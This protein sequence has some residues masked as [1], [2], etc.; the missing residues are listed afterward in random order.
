MGISKL[1]IVSIYFFAASFSAASAQDNHILNRL[2]K[3]EVVSS[4]AGASF[5]VQTLV[6]QAPEKVQ[7]MLSDL[8]S[9]PKV[10]PQIAFAVPYVGKGKDE[11]RNFLYLKMRGLGDGM[12]LLME[13]KSGGGEAFANAK[14]LIVNSDYSQSRATESEVDASKEPNHLEL[15][16][17]IDE[18]NAKGEDARFVGVGRSLILEGPLNYVMEMPNTR[19]TI[20]IGVSPYTQI[21]VEKP[22]DEK[23]A[24]DPKAAKKI[25]A[26]EK[27]TYLIA[28]LSVGNQVSHEEL[29]YNGFGDA[30]LS[31]AQNIGT[32]VFS[33]LRIKLEK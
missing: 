7:A 22:L 31:L 27:K 13:V 2:E 6:N 21:G 18:S 32:N 19:F 14:E 15:K 12:S 33:A 23:A 11:G 1:K 26:P 17:Q 10:F 29:D 4:K 5:F 28:K 3:G 25:A 16:S 8:S 20:S 24:K 9:L 30:R